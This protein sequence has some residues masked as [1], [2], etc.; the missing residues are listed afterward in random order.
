MDITVSKSIYTGFIK[1]YEGATLMH[2]ELNPAIR[3]TE[4]TAVVRRQ[5][6]LMMRL[7]QKKYDEIKVKRSQ[8][9]T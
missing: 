3:Y 2:C 8:R 6:Q 7:V 1:E 4:F 9:L 5:K